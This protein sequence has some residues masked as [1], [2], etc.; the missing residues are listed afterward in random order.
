MPVV[1]RGSVRS[2]IQCALAVLIAMGCSSSREVAPA[3][4][5]R[6]PS[7]ADEARA[8]A[9]SQAEQAG[10]LGMG[11]KNS[12]AS[13][14]PGPDQ[15]GAAPAGAARAAP[16]CAQAC[17]HLRALTLAE[18][19]KTVAALPPETAQKLRAQADSSPESDQA[20]CVTK[21]DA[22]AFKAGC[23]ANL[24]SIEDLHRCWPEGD[25]TRSRSANAAVAEHAAREAC[26]PFLEAVE[27]QESCDLL[28]S[29][30]DEVTR[31]LLKGVS[32]HTSDPTID[33]CLA[34]AL[35]DRCKGSAAYEASNRYL[36]GTIM[37]MP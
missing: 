35:E 37:A 2:S 22:G 30:L 5:E 3:P 19:E 27:A 16:S 24:L 26:G 28:A 18:L 10:L 17:K 34:V 21:C 8:L 33:R 15:H 11:K 13:L 32:N 23:V 36:A 31:A 14:E 1:A 12:Y 20:T 7:S 6:V 25:R 4:D 29:K 9:R